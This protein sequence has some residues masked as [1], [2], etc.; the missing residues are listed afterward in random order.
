MNFNTYYYL[1]LSTLGILILTYVYFKTRSDRTILIFLTMVEIAYLIE[2][3]IYIFLG[4]Y[5]YH[6]QILKHNAYYDSHMGALTSNLIAVPVLA[7]CV[8]VFQLNWMWILIFTGLLAGI[9]WIFV[10][11]NIYTLFW[12]R[13]GYTSVGLIVYFPLAKWLYRRLL[14]PLRGFYHSMFLFLCIAPL[15][16]T[17]QFLPFMLFSNRNYLP[18]WFVNPAYDTSAFGVVYYLC[19]S[20]LLVILA[21]FHWS[22]KRTK[23]IAMVLI[24]FVLNVSLKILGILHSLMWWDT[25]FYVLFPL[26]LLMITENISKRLS[27]G[28]LSR[29]KVT[30]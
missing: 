1:G 21:K 6:P 7:T 27:N 11:I 8:A 24:V 30:I 5:Q 20:L 13:I 14:Y 22:H 16:G 12:W 19:I 25:W 17:A 26:V 18:G 10:E 15:S 9:E 29:D 2:A 3:V 28:P 23:Y 4:A